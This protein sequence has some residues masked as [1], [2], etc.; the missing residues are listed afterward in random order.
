MNLVLAETVE[1]I[2]RPVEDGL[3]SEQVP[4]GLYIIRGDSVAVCGRLDEE[5]DAKIDWAKVHGEALGGMK[6][7]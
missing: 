7:V 4:L 1:R 5:L 6:H 3:P 2:I